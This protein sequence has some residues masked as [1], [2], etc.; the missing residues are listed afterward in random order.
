[1]WTQAKY[2]GYHS[3]KR[4]SDHGAAGAVTAPPIA[5]L[6]QRANPGVTDQALMQ[7]PKGGCMVIIICARDNQCERFGVSR[8]DA[9]VSAPARTIDA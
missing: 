1:M 8:L 7:L 3:K 6:G 4:D 5:S 9:V 2:C